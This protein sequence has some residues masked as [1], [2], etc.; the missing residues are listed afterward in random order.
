MSNDLNTDNVIEFSDKVELTQEEENLLKEEV[1]E[2]PKEQFYTT[3]ANLVNIAQSCLNIINNIFPDATEE[4]MVAAREKVVKPI[5]LGL[6]HE[7]GL[8]VTLLADNISPVLRTAPTV[9]P[10][11]RFMADHTITA[12][13]SIIH[14]FDP[15]KNS[16]QFLQD[17]QLLDYIW[18]K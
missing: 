10:T 6:L 14:G 11:T 16:E 9:D 18:N 12:M 8:H 15:A 2:D 17:K 3:P 5:I 13:Y 4:Q 7:M 1:S